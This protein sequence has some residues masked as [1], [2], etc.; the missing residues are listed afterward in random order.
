M[1]LASVLPALV[2]LIPNNTLRYTTLGLTSCLTLMYFVYLARPSTQL[3]RLRRKVEE[4]HCLIQHARAQCFRNNINLAA[5]WV[6]L[7][8][9]SQSTSRIRRSILESKRF[10][11][12]RCRILSAAIAECTQRVETIRTTVQL[13]AEAERQQNL[14]NDINETRSMLT[15]FHR[16]PRSNVPAPEW[17]IPYRLVL[18]STQ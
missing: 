17:A 10:S 1:I 3:H 11:W 5:E 2:A 7:L 4:V 14:E 9:V 15:S 16:A 18:A 12:N 8:E 6:Q 13:A